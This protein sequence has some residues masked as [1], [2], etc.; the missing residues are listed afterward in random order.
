MAIEGIPAVPCA[1]GSARLRRPVVMAFLMA[2]LCLAGCV[3][4]NTRIA[5]I[6]CV[7][8]R[9]HLDKGVASYNQIEIAN[10]LDEHAPKVWLRLPDGK[11]IDRPW[12]TF[13]NLQ[14]AGF[15]NVADKEYQPGSVY[16]HE[17]TAYGASFLFTGGTIA[18][19][20]VIETPDKKIGICLEHGKKF[21]TLP[22]TQQELEQLFGKPDKISDKWRL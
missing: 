1:A 11:I 9:A 18:L 10:P 14:A 2:A 21:F 12:F 3:S 13:G 16:D 8:A 6:G 15:V 5:D 20:R 22:M 19:L 7:T 17:L 4:N